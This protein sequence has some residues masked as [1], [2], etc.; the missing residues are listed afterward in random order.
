MKTKGLLFVLL[1]CT[2][3]LSYGQWYTTYMSDYRA[4]LGSAALESK[5]Y[6]AG[7]HN[8]TSSVT[9]VEIYDVVNEVWDDPINL[10]VA[11]DL[12]SCVA[13]GSRVFFAGGIDF[14]NNMESFREVDIWNTLTEEWTVEYLAVPRFD[15][16][17]ITYGNKVL[18]AGGADMALNVCYNIVD[19]YDTETGLWSTDTISMARSAMGAAVVGDLAIFAGGYDFNSV[20]DRVDIYNFSTNTWSTDTLSEA[21]GWCAALTIGNEVIIAGGMK[22]D[23][24][25]SDRVDIYNAST[26]IWTTSTP[27]SAPRAVAQRFSATVCDKAY[28]VGGGIYDYNIQLWTSTSDV[29]DIYDGVNWSVDSLSEGLTNHTVAGA[30]NHLVVAGGN[31]FQPP[32]WYVVSYVDIYVDFLCPNVIIHSQP[33]EEMF[34]KIYPNPLSSFATIEFELF[35]P[36]MVEFSIVTQAGQVIERILHHGTVGINKVRWDTGSLPAG[37]YL[38]RVTAGNQTATRKIVLVR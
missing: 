17:A 5:I 18:F 34:L 35:K 31:I 21:R 24:T 11:R 22:G 8:A 29:I 33:E 27:L 23:N 14:F 26:G 30:G 12:P 16:G 2:A 15:L 10:S 13:S 4:T 20:T 3:M 9:L 19:V 28:F 37:I 25:P 38:C 32:V 6:I 36:G 1:I 7:G